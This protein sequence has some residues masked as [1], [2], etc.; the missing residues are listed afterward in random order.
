M[1]DWLRMVVPLKHPP[2]DVG[3]VM[4]IDADGVVEWESMRR[5]MLEQPSHSA[6][7]MVKS[8]DGHNK[9]L[10][11]GNP[12]KWFQG[13]NLWGSDDLPSIAVA[14]AKS[15][16]LNLDVEVT[17]FDVQRWLLPPMQAFGGGRDHRI[18]RGIKIE[19]VDC[20]EGY[21]LDNI[22]DVRAWTRS[23]MQTTHMAHRGRAI[24]YG[25]TVYWGA[26]SRRW[27]IKAYPKGDEIARVPAKGQGKA[28]FFVEPRDGGVSTEI[29][30]NSDRSG[31]PIG[32]TDVPLSMN[33]YQRWFDL[34]QRTL[35]IEVTLRS[36]ELRR[37]G[38]DHIGAWTSGKT[39]EV[40]HLALSKLSL[41]DADMSATVDVTTLDLKGSEKKTYLLWTAGVDPRPLMSKPTFYRHRR[42]ILDALDIDI[43]NVPAKSN[44][45][46]LKRVLIARQQDVP[47]DLIEK[48]VYHPQIVKV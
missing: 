31:L 40:L 41:G 17:E 37:R 1:I 6:K 46:Q 39:A 35:R 20:T 12:A 44:V 13:H 11:D 5:K 28:S 14:F 34:A 3:R 47:H 19:R 43:S 48:F 26:K 36:M 21:L 2:M 18:A 23:A 10:I 15:V 22:H 30:V 8:I 16:A 38:L 25:E 42:A 45:V 7:V 9:L 33:D 27:S 32:N 29:N 24:S 4:A